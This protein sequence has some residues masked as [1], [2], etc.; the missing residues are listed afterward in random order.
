MSKATAMENGLNRE[1]SSFNLVCDYIF[2]A[3][4]FVRHFVK[5]GRRNPLPSK[6]SVLFIVKCRPQPITRAGD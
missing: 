3:F 1:V 4:F 2:V 6:I 5:S